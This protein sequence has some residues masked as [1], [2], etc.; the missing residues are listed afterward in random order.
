MSAAQGRDGRA[1]LRDHL[2]SPRH[3]AVDFLIAHPTL[4][5]RG[6]VTLSLLSQA[7]AARLRGGAGAGILRAATCTTPVESLLAPILSRAPPSRLDARLRSIWS[8]NRRRSALCRHMHSHCHT[9]RK[10]EAPVTTA[11]SSGKSSAAPRLS[12]SRRVYAAAAV[13]LTEKSP[14]SRDRTTATR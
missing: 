9:R 14:G 8:C 3:P 1:P 6:S 5:L 4:S 13:H 12:S 11:Q 2:S 10:V 7:R